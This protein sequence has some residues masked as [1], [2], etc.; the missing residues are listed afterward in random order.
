M[1]DEI[2]E[3]ELTFI[4]SAYRS[5]MTMRRPPLNLFPDDMLRFL[6]P[7]ERGCAAHQSS[8]RNG[9][10]FGL[11]CPTTLVILDRTLFENS[12]QKYD[13]TSG[14]PPPL[15]D[16][17]TV[18]VLT[19]DKGR[20]YIEDKG[21][22]VYIDEANVFTMSGDD[23]IS[24]PEMLLLV[25]FTVTPIMLLVGLYSRMIDEDRAIRVRTFRIGAL[26]LVGVGGAFPPSRLTA[27][28]PRRTSASVGPLTA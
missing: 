22:R 16:A 1:L 10:G 15:V 11:L 27:A 21:A 3:P 20:A 13:P 7:F 23:P 12:S 9:I 6:S 8:S 25:L 2:K 17:Q 28:R 4:F 14:V 19:D 18:P 5:M 26:P 24:I